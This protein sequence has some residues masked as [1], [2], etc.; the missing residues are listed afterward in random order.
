[1]IGACIHKAAEDGADTDAETENPAT[2][3]RTLS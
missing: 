3:G 1:M 2:R